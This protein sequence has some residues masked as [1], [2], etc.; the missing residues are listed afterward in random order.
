VLT[1][2][3]LLLIVHRS[4]SEAAK[5]G[6]TSESWSCY[7]YYS[8]KDGTAGEGQTVGAADGVRAGE[9]HHDVDIEDLGGQ[10]GPELRDTGEWRGQVH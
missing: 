9:R 5:S 1:P 6:S 10:P 3:P 7:S 4:S 8:Q 2:P